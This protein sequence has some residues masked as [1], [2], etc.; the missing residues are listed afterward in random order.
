MSSHAVLLRKTR[1]LGNPNGLTWRGGLF[2]M[3]LLVVCIVPREAD[4][5]SD[6]SRMLC[7]AFETLSSALSVITRPSHDLSR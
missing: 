2:E 1:R 4:I 7:N 5:L 6:V 3:C